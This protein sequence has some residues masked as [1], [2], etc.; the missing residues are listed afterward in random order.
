MGIEPR[1]AA[2][3]LFYHVMRDTNAAGVGAFGRAAAADGMTIVKPAV[4]FGEDVVCSHLGRLLVRSNPHRF[5]K[6]LPTKERLTTHP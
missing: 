4:L 6:V 3:V 2:A 5:M 1:G